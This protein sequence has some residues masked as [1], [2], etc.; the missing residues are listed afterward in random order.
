[1]HS[2]DT[3]PV[4]FH[5]ARTQTD[6]AGRWTADDILTIAKFPLVTVRTTAVLRCLPIAA[7]QPRI[8]KGWS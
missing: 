6:D 1:M 2:W 4:S 8:R 3:L 7:V 5:S